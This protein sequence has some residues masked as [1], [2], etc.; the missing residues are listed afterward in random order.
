MWSQI[1]KQNQ[2]KDRFFLEIKVIPGGSYNR[3]KE[4]M[5]N[6]TLKIELKAHPEKGRA[7]KQLIDYLA[8]EL[9]VD[10]NR[11]KIIKGKKTR[12]KIIKIC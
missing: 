4:K 11:V 8:R 6:G 2:G 9:E 1:K 5:P 3:L 12:T 10:R 7:N